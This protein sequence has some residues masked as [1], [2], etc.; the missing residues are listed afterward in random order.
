MQ[1]TQKGVFASFIL[2][3]FILILLFKFPILLKTYMKKLFTTLTFNVLFLF[4]TINANSQNSSYTFRIISP[5]TLSQ[6]D[7]YKQSI[8]SANLESYRLR[9]ERVILNFKGG[10]QVELYSAEEI[11]QRGISQIN[12]MDYLLSFPKDFKLPLFEVHSNGMLSAEFTNTTK[13]E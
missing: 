2:L 5:Y 10:F 1:A 9:N 4:I 11:L 7:F 3:N 12:P 6:E 13:I 8:A